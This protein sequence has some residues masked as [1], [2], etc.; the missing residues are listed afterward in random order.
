LQERFD[1]VPIE[2]PIFF[3][4]GHL[5][6]RAA[7]ENVHIRRL[8][9]VHFPAKP[10]QQRCQLRYSCPEASEEIYGSL[11]WMGIQPAP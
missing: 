7:N 2:V 5:A 6:I 11:R 9:E 8:D 10:C 1:P 3:R 4:S